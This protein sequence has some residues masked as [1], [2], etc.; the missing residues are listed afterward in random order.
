MALRVKICGCC[1]AADAALIADAGADAVGFIQWPGSKRYV[2]PEAVAA[3]TADL[4]AA[5]LKVAV[6]VDADR[7]EIE[8]VMATG[9]FD[10]AQLHGRELPALVDGLSVRC[11]KAVHLNRP[12]V[13]PPESYAVEAFLLDYHGGA[14]PG[15]TGQAV[16]WPAAAQWVEQSPKPVMLAGGLQPDNVADAIR[17]VRPAG[18]DVSSGVEAAVGRKDAAKVK[19]FIAACRSVN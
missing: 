7:D 13:A 9:R 5:L 3:W 15:G 10:V 16:D 19:D 17:V 11:W 8:R 1:S 18:V 12:P 2:E 4:P 6:F 14:Q